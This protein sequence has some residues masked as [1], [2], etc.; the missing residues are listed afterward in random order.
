MIIGFLG[1][2]LVLGHG[3]FARLREHFRRI[4]VCGLTRARF[5]S[6]E[7]VVLGDS[8]GGRTLSLGLPEILEL[9]ELM[10]AGVAC[11]EPSYATG[12]THPHASFESSER[13]ALPY[14]SAFINNAIAGRAFQPTPSE[15]AK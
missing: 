3:E 1:G 5:E 13:P 4:T 6:G 2:W 9:T 11:L 7:R 14:Q 10:E 15:K 8:V 12:Y